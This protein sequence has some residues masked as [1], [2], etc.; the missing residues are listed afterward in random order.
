M[1][2][3][4]FYF[5]NNTIFSNNCGKIAK[6]DLLYC[7]QVKI[8]TY[9]CPNKT[10]IPDILYNLEELYIHQDLD[11]IPEYFKNLKILYCNNTNIKNIPYF[12]KLKYLDCSHNPNLKYLS[13][14]YKDIETFKHRYSNIEFV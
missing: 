13:K 4:N 9:V 8:L 2:K 12:P 7:N 10:I 6:L 3:T 1:D 11:E 5:A 14:K